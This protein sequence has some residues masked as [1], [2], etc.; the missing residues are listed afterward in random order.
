MLASVYLFA[1]HDELRLHT[2]KKIA[3]I[4]WTI[5]RNT[6]VQKSTKNDKMKDGML[7]MRFELMISCVLQILPLLL[8]EVLKCETGVLPL[9]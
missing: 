2:L 8:L 4:N 5:K 6:G 9:D 7:S 3:K 1:M